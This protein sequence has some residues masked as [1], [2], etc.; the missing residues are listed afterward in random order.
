MTVDPSQ[1]AFEDKRPVSAEEL[2]ELRQRLWADGSVRQAEAEELFA[3]NAS[4]EP[5]TEWTDF[6]VEALCGYLIENAEPRGYVGDTAAA[7]LIGQIDSDGQVESQAELEL[8]V[9]LLER[10]DYAPEAL[11]TFALAQIE[12]IVTTGN[13]P[14]RRGGTL[15]PGRIDNA[16]VVLLRRL[17]F[18]PA[19]D[20]PAKVSKAEAELL[21]RLKDATL[22]AEN[23]PEWKKLFVQGV[24]NHLLAH[25]TYV[26]PSPEEEM[27]LEAPYKADPFGHIL[28]RLGHEV[29]GRREFDDAVFGDVERERIAALKQA[30]AADAQVTQGESDWLKRLFE[31]DGV[32][33][34]LEQA[35]VDF[36]AEDRTRPF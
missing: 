35:L 26:A 12:K 27:R 16:E 20:G 15:T 23:S 36:L 9:K 29:P 30:A 11:K 31:Q 10:A 33:D 2:R 32:R 21:F 5:S 24:A 17:I 22:G 3:R 14:T 28:S 1:R 34:E 25:Q 13:G 7:W 19:G 18:A 4:A 6:F 8:I